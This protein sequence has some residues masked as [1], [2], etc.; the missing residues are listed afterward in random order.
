LVTIAVLGASVDVTVTLLDG[1]VVNVE[2]GFNVEW[3]DA[4]TVSVNPAKF[5]PTIAVK[6][7]VPVA[8]GCPFA[9]SCPPPGGQL[10]LVGVIPEV[11][12]VQAASED[13]AV[14]DLKIVPY[15]LSQIWSITRPPA[16]EVLVIATV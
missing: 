10:T 8:P 16:F 11:P 15:W 1:G 3:T 14:K 4:V 12:A 5:S 9:A 7:H 6:E 2:L 13:G